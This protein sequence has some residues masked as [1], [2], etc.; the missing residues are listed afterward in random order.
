MKIILFQMPFIIF[1]PKSTLFLW[2]GEAG[3]SN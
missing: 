3:L 1:F 2:N